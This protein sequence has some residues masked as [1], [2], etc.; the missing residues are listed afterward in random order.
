MLLCLEGDVKLP[1]F[2]P[3]IGDLNSG[4]MFAGTDVHD[5]HGRS[6]TVCTPRIIH[7]SASV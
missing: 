3:L 1:S 7:F 2:P 5:V 4:V 6:V